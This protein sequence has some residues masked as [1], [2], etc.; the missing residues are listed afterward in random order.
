[1]EPCLLRPS[2]AVEP[3]LLLPTE[4]RRRQ[5]W[6]S[7]CFE[8]RCERCAA[9]EDPLRAVACRSCALKAES[10]A[11]VFRPGVWLRAEPSS[12]VTSGVPREQQACVP[13]SCPFSASALL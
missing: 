4:L 11:V 8:C 9:E 6:R 1:M 12:S 10:Y 2:E 13:S 5:L 3:R 7:K